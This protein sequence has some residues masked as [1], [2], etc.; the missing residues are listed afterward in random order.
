MFSTCARRSCALAVLW[1]Y[2]GLHIHVHV[3]CVIYSVLSTSTC[4]HVLFYCLLTSLIYS[5]H[6]GLVPSHIAENSL[7]QSDGGSTINLP[8]SRS[9]SVVGGEE[10][11][12]NL[13][14]VR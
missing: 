11:E 1:S 13:T 4:G 8:G 7:A 3:Q 2:L 6:A 14:M 10:D 12:D 9:L 5:T